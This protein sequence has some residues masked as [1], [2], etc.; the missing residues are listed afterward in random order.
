MEFEQYPAC[1]FRYLTRADVITACQSVDITGV[2]EDAL[3]LHEEGRTI[4]P[5]EAYLGWTA[6]DGHPAR[7]LAMPG[8]IVSGDRQVLGLKTINASLGNPRR[9]LPRSQGFTILLDAE[10][11]QPRA[12]MEAAYDT[13]AGRAA[14]FAD[15]VKALPGGASVECLVAD[16]ARP[17][18]SAADLIV[19]VTTTTKGYIE[20]DWLKPGA[21]VA[22][23]SLD[24][25]TE[26]AVLAAD[27]V[28]VDDWSLVS[29]DPR[30]LLGRMY[31]A[32]TLLDQDG[33]PRSGVLEAPL[34][35]RVNGSL[36]DV[37]TGRHPGRSS[38]TE[39]VISN[40]FGMSVLD[41]VVGLSGRKFSISPESQASR[42]RCSS[43]T[44][45][46]VRQPVKGR[47]SGTFRSG[48]A[49]PRPTLEARTFPVTAARRPAHGGNDPWR[50]GAGPFC[51][52]L[53]RR[54]T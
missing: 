49:V 47:L 6:P 18:V 20:A 51:Q 5:E 28:I 45:T 43:G 29:A 21:L 39:I 13:S 14:E 9:G 2:V 37:L 24:D 33:A 34:A 4:L 35:R 23:V 53:V 10:T 31:R 3:R 17:C 25:L 44:K 38:E 7:M 32:G 41:G 19:P 15:F 22:H 26:G 36:G 42:R 50:R 52:T 40:P 11:A 1:E 12:L 27:L 54:G 30:R 46:P 16:V 48:P 8:A